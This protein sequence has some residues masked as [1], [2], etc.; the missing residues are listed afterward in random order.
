LQQSLCLEAEGMLS[1]Y[2]ESLGYLYSH[3]IVWWGRP[4]V[5]IRVRV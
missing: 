3:W 2:G 4:D 5:I 1:V